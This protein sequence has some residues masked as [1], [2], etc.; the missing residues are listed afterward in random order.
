M[1][2]AISPYLNREIAWLA[3]N[4]RVLREAADPTNPIVERMIFLGIFSNNNDEF[5]RV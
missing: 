1:K 3:F 2:K 5:Y 4:E